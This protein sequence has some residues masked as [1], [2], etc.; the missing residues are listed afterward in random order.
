MKKTIIA[1]TVIL[2]ILAL[3]MYFFS[4]SWMNFLFRPNLKK[5]LEILISEQPMQHPVVTDNQLSDFS[6]AVESVTGE[7]GLFTS[8]FDYY[9]KLAPAFT[10]FQDTFTYLDFWEGTLHSAS[11]FPCIFF[12]RGG[13][14]YVRESIGNIVPA[15]AVITAINSQPIDE[16]MNYFQQFIYAPSVEERNFWAIERDLLN[17]YPEFFKAKEFKIEY[18]NNGTEYQEIID[19]VPWKEFSSWRQRIQSEVYRFKQDGD[20]AVL[21]LYDLSYAE[22]NVHKI[23]EIMLQIIDSKVPKLLIDLSDT[24]GIGDNYYTLQ[25][26]LSFFSENED[27]L[28]QKQITRYTQQLDAFAVIQQNQIYQ[29]AVYFLIS[30]Y[31]IYPYLSTL[32]SFCQRTNTGL[33]IGTQPLSLGSF[34]SNPNHEPLYISYLIPKV[35][36]TYNEIQPIN[37]DNL[38]VKPFLFTNEDYI[39]LMFFTKD[40]LSYISDFK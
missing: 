31:S 29:G 23:K 36:R 17:Y 40:Y 30:D 12:Y 32:I 25:M 18:V 34:L 26:L 15:G 20:L 5:E 10:L 13:K 24:K 4:M 11:V 22:Q 2:M 35:C 9:E 1:Y 3:L 28:I 6:D 16:I 14:V 21:K 39:E 33:F 27:Y 38:I 19:R 37:D 7:I 8:H